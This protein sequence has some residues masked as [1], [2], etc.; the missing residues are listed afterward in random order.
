[1]SPA[2]FSLYVNDLE[3]FMYSKN[4]IGLKSIS[5]EIETELVNYVKLFF[6]L[7]AD[8][9]TILSESEKSCRQYMYYTDKTFSCDF[10]LNFARIKHI[11]FIEFN[12]KFLHQHHVMYFM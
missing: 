8:D 9:T 7:Y 12:T 11:I 1:M 5:D 6:I 4:I 3:D 2:L 10:Y